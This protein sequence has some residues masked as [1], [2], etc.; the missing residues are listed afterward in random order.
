MSRDLKADLERSNQAMQNSLA[1]WYDFLVAN[2]ERWLNEAIAEKERAD[3][4]EVLV[5]EL[6]EDI[7]IIHDSLLDKY[8][9]YNTFSERQAMRYLLKKAKKVLGDE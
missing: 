6:A 5:R 7:A 4:Y 8:G 1:N 3:K 9:K 2:G